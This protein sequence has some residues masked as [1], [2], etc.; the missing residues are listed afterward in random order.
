MGRDCGYLALIAGVAGGAEAIVL[1]EVETDSATRVSRNWAFEGPATYS[2][3]SS[4]T[5]SLID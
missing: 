5:A 4:R 2:L 1:P 3:W